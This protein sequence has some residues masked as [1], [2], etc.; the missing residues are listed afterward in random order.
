MSR[1]VKEE[2]QFLNG[3]AGNLLGQAETPLNGKLAFLTRDVEFM[4]DRTMLLAAGTV[5]VRRAARLGAEFLGANLDF[6]QSETFADRLSADVDGSITATGGKVVIEWN[7]EYV[8]FRS[9]IV[10]APFRFQLTVPGETIA[11]AFGWQFTAS[12]GVGLPLHRDRDSL[13]VIL[14]TGEVPGGLYFRSAE[15]GD[16]I[17]PMGMTGHKKIA[18]LMSEAGLTLAARQRLPIICDMVGPIWVPGIA[19]DE[20]VKVTD[21]PKRPIRLTFEPTVG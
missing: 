3:V 1:I 8:H 12:S 17:Q 19:I 15:Q 10:D 7:S 9:L 6:H 4:V 16:R 5:L 13:E 2:D 18:D 11:D 14:E 21:Q 20:R